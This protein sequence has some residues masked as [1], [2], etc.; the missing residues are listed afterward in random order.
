M[1][2]IP[3]NP[4]DK[5]ALDKLEDAVDLSRALV[6]NANELNRIYKKAGTAIQDPFAKATKSLA[7]SLSDMST[8]MGKMS[9]DEFKRSEAVKL[10][11]KLAEDI[12]RLKTEQARIESTS[13][14]AAQ[15]N[16]D[17]AKRLKES[18]ELKYR[19]AVRQKGKDSEEAARAK[20]RVDM[21]VRVNDKAKE[22]LRVET[23]AKNTAKELVKAAEEEN[24]R[25]GIYIERWNQVNLRMGMFGS[26]LKKL[27]KIPI[28]GDVL[29]IDKGLKDMEESAKA[30]ESAFKTMG[31]GIS[32]AFEGI[33]KSTIILA[34]ISAAV[35]VIKF[36][37][38]AMLQADKQVTD[39]ARNMGITKDQASKVRDEMT[40]ISKHAKEFATLNE[41]TLISQKE[42]FETQMAFNDAFGTS[43][44]LSATM[45]TQLVAAKNIIGLSDEAMQGL[46][47]TMLATGETV[48]DIEKTILGTSRII[49]GNSTK[50]LQDK[51]ALESVLKLTG[52]IR[53]NL[54]GSLQAMTAAVAQAIKMGTTLE[55]IDATASSLL[56]FESSIQSQMEAEVLTGKQLNLDR[57]RYAALTGDTNTLMEELVKNVGTYNQYSNMNRIQQEAIAKALGMSRDD[58]A[59]MLL[60]QSAMNRLSR[61]AGFDAQ[62]TLIE[63]Y[64]ILKAQGK[65]N[66]IAASDQAKEALLA[67]EQQSAQEKFAKALE[68]AKEAFTTLVDG[69]FLDK[70]A[71]IVANLID[72]LSGAGH[73]G[74]SIERTAA[75]SGKQVSAIDKLM[76]QDLQ[77]TIDDQPGMIS[78]SIFP[79]FTSLFYGDKEDSDKKLEAARKQLREIQGRYENRGDDTSINAKD[80]TIN[81]LPQDT[82]SI[83]GGTKLGRTDEM[84]KHQEKQNKLLEAQNQLLAIIASK[85]YTLDGQRLTN[86]VANTVPTLYGN[87]L[88]IGSSN[89]YS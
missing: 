83:A 57:A 51:K 23:D 28:L 76:I 8:Q 59:D 26:A 72:N 12:R 19:T 81:T 53:L 30:N 64:N 21:A 50:F 29:N 6:D 54:K 69:G 61:I 33:E 31:S 38:D 18:A 78:R 49:Q 56:D 39:I 47:T 41:G 35:K 75:A 77:K 22:R 67:L 36:L 88:N 87:L 24:D 2:D 3:K 74:E 46:K 40:Y 16:A 63:N 48:E 82:I 55:K 42:I 73:Y 58:M 62:K 45:I 60:K 68:R 65:L 11:K 34:A 84:V 85:D 70:F 9:I 7:K 37:I 14:P 89:P 71:D 15:K 52:G 80:F 66:D 79:F 5:E 13:L 86:G 27:K 44:Q 32:A 25:L 1:A 17:L 10:Q 4:F 20:E 43:V